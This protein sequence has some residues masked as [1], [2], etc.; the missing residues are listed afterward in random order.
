[1]LMRKEKG[2]SREQ[3]LTSI[4]RT[5]DAVNRT[6]IASS[7]LEGMYEQVCQVIA[8]YQENYL[9]AWIGLVDERAVRI[10]SRSEDPSGYLEEGFAISLDEASPLS[11]GPAGQAILQNRTIVVKDTRKDTVFAPWKERAKAAG[12]RSVIVSPLSR[13]LS[14]TPFGAMGI[15]SGRKGGFEAEE[16]VMLEEMASGR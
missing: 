2:A 3:Y 4:L 8:R 6:L 12:V 5:M 1:M 16:V 11:K 15:Y 10:V 13:N 7:S 9:L 14:S